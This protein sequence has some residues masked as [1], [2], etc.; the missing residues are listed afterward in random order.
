MEK[1]GTLYLRVMANNTGRG[2]ENVE[3]NE[4]SNLHQGFNLYTG[5]QA[6]LTEDIWYN[7]N[8]G[9]DR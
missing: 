3:S 8:C 7:R 6:T 1:L 4:N 9:G 2:A 5:A